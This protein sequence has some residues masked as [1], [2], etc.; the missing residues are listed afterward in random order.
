[1]G[2]INNFN[3]RYGDIITKTGEIPYSESYGGP[4]TTAERMDV[5]IQQNFRNDEEI[6]RNLDDMDLPLLTSS[7]K[8]VVARIS[9]DGSFFRKQP[10]QQQLLKEDFQIKEKKIGNFQILIK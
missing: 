5:Y 2:D 9:F 8:D 4:P 10:N 3:A 7:W 6:F 1:M